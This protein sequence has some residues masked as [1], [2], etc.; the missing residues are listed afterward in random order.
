GRRVDRPCSVTA[1]QAHLGAVF[2]SVGAVRGSPDPHLVDVLD[3]GE[4]G[5]AGP[6]PC[7]LVDVL[8]AVAAC[9][10]PVLP[11]GRNGLEVPDV[12]GDVGAQLLQDR[13]SVV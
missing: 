4:A 7:A 2:R 8:G 5:D 9:G 13:K 10:D 3:S 11:V 12:L 1:A 6:L